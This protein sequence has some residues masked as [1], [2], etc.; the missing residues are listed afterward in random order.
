MKVLAAAT[1][2]AAYQAVIAQRADAQDV[3]LQAGPLQRTSG[4]TPTGLQN[5]TVQYT[6]VSESNPAGPLQKNANMDP[7]AGFGGGYPDV[8]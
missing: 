5:Y 8:F 3:V 2:L 1:P 4:V 6:S 7:D